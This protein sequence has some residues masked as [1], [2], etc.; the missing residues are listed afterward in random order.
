MFLL[1]DQ[2]KIVDAEYSLDLFE[3]SPCV[4]IESSGGANPA[5]GIKRRNPDYNKL[6]SLVFRRLAVSGIQITQVVLDSSKVSN[7][8]VEERIAILDKSY[9]VDLESIDIEDFR[10][11]LQREIASMHRDPSAK[12]GGNAQKRIR[13]CLSKSV[14]PDQLLAESGNSESPAQIPNHAP[15]LNETETKYL[16]TARLGQG[17]FR[18]D[19]LNAYGNTCPI[20]GIAN[21]E[22]LI[23]SHIKPWKACTNTERLD[24]ENGILDEDGCIVISPILSPMDSVKCGLDCTRA[25]DFSERSRHYMQYHRTIEFKN[26]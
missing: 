24:P 1:D 17:Q 10:K 15:G 12:K 9:P 18:K 16:R 14:A 2:N 23:A 25:I 5:R 22:L 19:L 13:I 26:N 3:E 7:I 4:V 20:T 8:P 11:M 21:S 6:L